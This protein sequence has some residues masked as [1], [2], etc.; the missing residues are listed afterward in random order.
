MKMLRYVFRVAETFKKWRQSL[1]MTQEQAARALGL[2]ARNVQNYESGA[3]SPPETV[4]RLMS[5]V[6]SGCN[7]EPWPTATKRARK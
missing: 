4:L 2:T 7:C 3:Y 5:A 6:A 1:D